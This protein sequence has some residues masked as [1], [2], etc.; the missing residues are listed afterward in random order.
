MTRLD[1][2]LA[3]LQGNEPLNLSRRATLLAGFG[4]GLLLAL[5]IPQRPARAQAMGGLAHARKVPSYLTIRPDGRILLQNPF[6]EGGQGI[7]TAVAQIV[8]EELDADLAAFEVQTAAAGPDYQVLF[9]GTRRVTGGSFSIRN[10]F[11]HFRVLGATA[12]AMLLAAGARRLGVPAAELGTEPGFVVHAASGRRIPYGELAEEAAALPVPGDAQPKAGA[13]RLIGT[14]ASRLDTRAKSTGQAQYGIDMRVDGML[15]A[16]VVHA[17][18]AG[19]EPGEVLNEAALREMPGVHSVHRLPGA[20]AVLADS[21]W[22]ARKA[23]EAAEVAWT[24]LSGEPVVPEDFSSAGMRDALRTQADAPGNPASDMQGDAATALR[25]AAKVVTADYDAPYLAH[26]QLE[27]PSAT[28]RF[29]A[30]GTLDVWTP[31]QAPEAFQGIAARESGLAAEQVR[32]HTPLLG[33]FFGR[34]FTYGSIHPMNQAIRLARAVGKPVKVI[35]TREEEFSRDAYRP[36]GFARLRAGLDAAGRIIALHATVPGE[37]PVAKHF[38]AAR[39]G[40]PPVDSSAVEGVAFKPYAIPN[41]RVEWVH[42]AHP[43]NVGFWRSVGHSMNDFFYEAFLDEVADAA[44]ADPLAF[45]RAHLAGQ[46]RHLALLDAVVDLSGGWRRGP[47]EAADGTRRARGLAMAS[48]FGSEVATVA[49]VSLR[50]GEAVVHDLFVAIDPGSIVN[51]AI[52]KAQVESAACIGLSSAA[53]EEVVF[54]GG[55]PQQRNFDTY[56]ILMR[57]EMPKVH[58]RIVES[59]A[60]MGGVGEPGTPGVPPAVA[61]AIAVLTGR[62]IRSLPFARH[63]LGQA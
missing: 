31:N 10:S 35:W 40:N 26:A 30:D 8:A 5:G 32:I 59:G 47:F 29:N 21:F 25:D 42:V 13:W 24:A 9:N 49:E 33:G 39:M 7:H 51:P 12:R 53:F 18:R 6:A 54:E 34:H 20:V 2:A 16:A 45:R 38:G 3:A 19:A 55:R 17:P 43:V 1:D 14:P 4:G 41:R 62:R 61:N 36:M 27:P 58:V 60:P 56:R 11:A 28:V 15:Q 22:R 52:I 50:D 63:R 37:G 57:G 44:G 48:P 23:V 46:P